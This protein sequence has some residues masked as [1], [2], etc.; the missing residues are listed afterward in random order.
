MEST[1]KNFEDYKAI[2]NFYHE[3]ESLKKLNNQKS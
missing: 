2:H 3:E 1:Q